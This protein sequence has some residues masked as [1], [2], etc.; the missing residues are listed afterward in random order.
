MN[1]APVDGMLP[2]TFLLGGVRA[3]KS[4]KALQI[5]QTFSRESNAGSVLFVATAQPFDAEMTH[6]ITAHK[7]ERPPEWRTLEEPV[8]IADG[9]AAS[10][11]HHPD[12]RIVV[13][14]CLTLWV[15][16]ILLSCA[17]GD[18][19]EGIVS[20]RTTALLSVMKR[21]SGGSTTAAREHRW[22]VVSNEVGLGIVPPT[23]LGRQYRDA[24]GRANQLVAAA[25]DEVTLM[26][27]GLEIP[28]KAGG[29]PQ[30]RR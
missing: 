4:A 29:M 19:V 20:S 7:A 8:E 6:R 2:L 16:N 25:A 27:A 11:A 12:L 18:D 26:V 14:D 28:L 21:F 9:I 30:L 3:G 5:A 1:G 15:S 10:L 17:N 13:V 23:P 24:L 22:I